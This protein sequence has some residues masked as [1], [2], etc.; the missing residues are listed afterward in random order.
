MGVSVEVNG[1][2]SRLVETSRALVRVEEMA[3]GVGDCMERRRDRCV[4]FF[5]LCILA[6]TWCLVR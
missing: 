1:V 4:P 2:D 5:L 6:D 3:V